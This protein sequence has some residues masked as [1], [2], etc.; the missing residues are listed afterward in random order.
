MGPHSII[1]NRVAYNEA[2]AESWKEQTLLNLVR[3]RY[4]DLVG[5]SEVSQIVSSYSFDRSAGADI[6]ISPAAA[7]G[8]GTA[9]RIRSL[10]K[11]NARYSD[12][13]TIT[14]SPKSGSQFV[15]RLSA[16]IRPEVILFLIESGYPADFVFDLTVAS[17]NGLNNRRIANRGYEPADPE[18]TWL[19]DVM[20]RAQLSRSVSSRVKI[21]SE[22]NEVFLL[23]LRSA[24]R[25]PQLE[26]DLNHAKEILNLDTTKSEFR[27][28]SGVIQENSTEIVI[29]TR[30]LLLILR[31]LVP[32]VNVPAEHLA[33]GSAIPLDVTGSSDEWP[34]L[35][36]H[37]KEKPADFFTAVEYR[38]Y[39]FWVDDRHLDSK[40]TF[41]YLMF[42][43]AQAE[44]T[45]GERLP[46]V[47][48][49][50]N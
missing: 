31:D 9:D 15:R 7:P 20:R 38:G 23:G 50:A 32:F 17:I 6:G 13:P 42:L 2:V 19:I 46:L 10:L 8:V 5:F 34:L 37:S 44:R 47:T 40:R 33:D 48:I 25:D 11:L 49:Q 36:C 12:R 43:L 22:K 24:D 30:P 14:Y 28:L 29:Q 45:A 35:V 3:M 21:D 41:F 4:A 27:V 39:W 1:E 16:T 26:T 18:F